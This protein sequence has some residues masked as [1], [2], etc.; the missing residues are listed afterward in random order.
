MAHA[1]SKNAPI[2]ANIER[3]RRT[4]VRLGL[5]FLLCISNIFLFIGFLMALLFAELHLIQSRINPLLAHQLR[6]G[7]LLGDAALVQDDDLIG[8][9]YRCQ[10][11]GDAQGPP[12]PHPRLAW[13]CYLP[14]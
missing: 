14:L 4:C 2:T 1:E 10:P 6:L 12:T 5:D 7:A 13:S 8:I 11:M 3:K 9:R